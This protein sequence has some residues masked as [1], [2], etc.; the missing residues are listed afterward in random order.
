MPAVIEHLTSLI[1][2]GPQT[3][4]WGD[5]WTKQVVVR[6]LCPKSVELIGF[7]AG[8]QRFTVSD[9][10]AV[11]E[12]LCGLGAEEAQWTRKMEDGTERLIKWKGRHDLYEHSHKYVVDV[13]GERL[14]RM[15]AGEP[16]KDK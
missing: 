11:E 12:L 5:P 14:S 15:A 10:R 2:I 4:K 16:Q 9:F 8:G 13:E 3:H 7:D 6:W 1:R